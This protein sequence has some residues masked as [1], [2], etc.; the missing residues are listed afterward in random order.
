MK[1]IQHDYTDSSNTTFRN[2]NHK[3]KYAYVP[4]ALSKMLVIFSIY[5]AYVTR[6][7]NF[8]LIFVMISSLLWKSKY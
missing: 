2:K 5:C 6:N 1:N 7:I 3:E 8:P 4:S